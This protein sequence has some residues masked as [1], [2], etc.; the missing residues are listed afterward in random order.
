MLKEMP[1]EEF[2]PGIGIR[3]YSF[4]DNPSLPKQVKE[5]WLD[6]Q[7]C[8]EGKEGCVASNIT[9]SS[10]VL[11][12]PKRSNEDTVTKNLSVIYVFK[13]MTTL[14]S[15]LCFWCYTSVQGDFFFLQRCQ[16][17]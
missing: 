9:S 5:S 13:K 1:E 15:L 17:D 8:Q 2:G 6:V 12:Y 14:A 16:S 11:K 10:G 3:E 7:L 4:L